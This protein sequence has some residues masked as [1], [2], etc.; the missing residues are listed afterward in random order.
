M[1]FLAPLLELYS[2]NLKDLVPECLT[3][4]NLCMHRDHQ[5]GQS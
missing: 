3:V 5:S 4:A 2:L 1:V